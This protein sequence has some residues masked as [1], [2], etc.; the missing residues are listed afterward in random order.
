MIHDASHLAEHAFWQLLDLTDNAIIA[1]HSNCRAI[2]G[3][4]SNRHLTDDMIKAL[5][6]RDGVIGINF[7]T[8]F[9]IRHDKFPHEKSSLADVLAHVKHICDLAGS[10]NQVALWHRYGRWAWAR[11][12]SGGDRDECGLTSRR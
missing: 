1:S 10:A 6:R 8:Q 12:D 3:G 11:A 4:P 7:C 2:V 9:L 5:V